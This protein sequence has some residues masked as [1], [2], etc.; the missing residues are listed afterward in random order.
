MVQCFLPWQAV[1]G[2]TRE[3]SVGRR[4]P[5]DRAK[6]A[7]TLSRAARRLGPLLPHY[8]DHFINAFL[9]GVRDPEWLVRAASLSALGDVCKEL[10]FSLGPIVQEVFSVLN[11]AVV[12]DSSV[13]VRRAAVLVVT[14]LLQGLGG[15]ALKVLREVLR[16]LYRGLRRLEATD[17]DPVVRLHAQLAL[18]EVDAIMR[19]FLLPSAGLTKRIYVMDAPPPAL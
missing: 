11:L 4:T 15:D 5:E 7:E 19:R 3:F 16:E 17:A 10:R 14:M 1:G 9:A 18:Q 12:Q 8:K 6:L 13:E 2:L